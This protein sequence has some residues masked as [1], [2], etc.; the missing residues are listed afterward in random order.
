MDTKM[1]TAAGLDHNVPK[2][3]MAIDNIPT[4]LA[5]CGMMAKRI[6]TF[7]RTQCTLGITG[8]V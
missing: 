4:T 5:C 6:E 7:F 2:P 3:V 8:S 1:G